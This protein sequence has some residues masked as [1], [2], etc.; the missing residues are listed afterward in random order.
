MHM[1]LFHSAIGGLVFIWLMVVGVALI[2]GLSLSELCSP[3]WAYLIIAISSV[4]EIVFFIWSIIYIQKSSL[5]I[6]K[7][8]SR[9]LIFMR[10]FFKSVR[11]ISLILIVYALINLFGMIFIPCSGKELD[12]IVVFAINLLGFALFFF[13]WMCIEIYKINKKM[14]KRMKIWRWT[15]YEKKGYWN[16][17]NLFFE[18]R[19]FRIFLHHQR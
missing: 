4:F 9:N 18:I 2:F 8:S 10:R 3:R 12:A 6:F 11:I 13:I 15:M 1:K 16:R 14:N 7:R 5:D 17:N 19:F